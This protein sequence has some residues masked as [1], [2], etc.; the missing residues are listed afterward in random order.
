MEYNMVYGNCYFKMESCRH[1]KSF[2]SHLL[3]LLGWRW[4]AEGEDRCEE[5]FRILLFQHED[6]NWWR[7]VEGEDW[8]DWPETDP[9]QMRGN[10][11]MVGC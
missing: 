6:D 1:F 5:Q 11:K 10:D 8:R 7:E 3:Y 4:T 9:G 2:E